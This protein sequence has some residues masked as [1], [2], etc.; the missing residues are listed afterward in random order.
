MA[1]GLHSTALRTGDGTSSP[2]Y[3]K[4]TGQLLAFM[5][6]VGLVPSLVS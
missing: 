4:V 1:L 2:A 3:T 6:E 5:S